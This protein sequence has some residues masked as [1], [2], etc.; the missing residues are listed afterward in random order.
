MKKIFLKSNIQQDIMRPVADMAAFFDCSLVEAESVDAWTLELSLEQA[1]VKG[2]LGSAAE[3]WQYELPL[4]NFN[5]GQEQQAPEIWPSG[6]ISRCVKLVTVELLS[7][8]LGEKPQLPWGVLTGVRPGK[9][10]HKLVKAGYAYKELKEL[11]AEHYLLPESQ[12]GML[13]EICRLQDGLAPLEEVGIYIGIPFC[14]SRCS[15]CSFPSGIIPKDEE[16]QQNFINLIELELQ[17]VVQLISMYKLKVTSLYIGGGTPTSLSEKCF[18]RLL[19]VVKRVLQLPALREFTVEAG[20]PDCFTLGKLSSME[21]AGVNRISVNPQTFHDRTLKLIGRSH[22]VADFYRAYELT[23]NSRIPVINLDLILGLPGERA[24]DMEYSLQEAIKLEPENLTVHTLTLKKNSPLY[25]IGHGKDLTPQEAGAMV[26]LGRAMSE[27]AGYRPYY[28]YRQ[29]YMLGHLANIGYAKPGT[30]GIYNIQ[31]ME[32]RHTVIGVGPSSST[33][34]PLKDG[35]HLLSMS[36]P[37]NLV[38]YR[39]KLADYCR[40]REELFREES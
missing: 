4:H 14:P 21:E 35:H 23:R 29:H 24:E 31:M 38:T 26:E 33:K 10:A 17:Y 37:K 7:Q 5:Q 9:L 40:K 32:E 25:S 22:S 1:R 6:E 34:L 12:G 19:K 30:E 13:A 28:L 11:F 20:R 18:D 16:S 8:A 2:V 36:M 15:Y 27:R 3:G 39:E